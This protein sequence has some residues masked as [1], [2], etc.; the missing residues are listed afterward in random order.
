MFKLILV[1][2]LVCKQTRFANVFTLYERSV[3]NE[4]SEPIE[5]AL[6]IPDLYTLEID[7]V[8]NNKMSLG[9]HVVRPFLERRGGGR[10]QVG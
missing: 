1:Y 8:V 6:N 10:G 5:V 7:R 3:C 2:F 4:T 9:R